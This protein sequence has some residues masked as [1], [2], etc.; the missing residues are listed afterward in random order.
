MTTH[1]L[2]RRLGVIYVFPIYDNY[3]QLLIVESRKKNLTKK[4]LTKLKNRYNVMYN[5][6]PSDFQAF[7]EAFTFKQQIETENLL[8]FLC[9]LGFLINKHI[10]LQHYS[11]T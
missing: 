8:D 2:I 10:V 7:R 9:V 4:D 1:L 5:V 11:I 3:Y 6:D